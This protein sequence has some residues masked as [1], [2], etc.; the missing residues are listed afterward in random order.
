MSCIFLVEIMENKFIAGEF[1]GVDSG[2]TTATGQ[3]PHV[4]W[5]PLLPPATEL[6]QGLPTEVELTIP[7]DMDVP[8]LL[9]PCLD[10][11]S[12]IEILDVEEERPDILVSK[13]TGID[14][15]PR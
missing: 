13:Q 11:D 3:Q 15:L 1:G 6:E 12:D 8:P 7:G 9:H 10:L 14:Q 2:G 4:F 5:D